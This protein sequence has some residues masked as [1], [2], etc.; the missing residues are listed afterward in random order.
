MQGSKFVEHIYDVDWRVG[1]FSNFFFRSSPS[2][3]GHFKIDDLKKPLKKGLNLPVSRGLTFYYSALYL[4][5]IIQTLIFVICQS[6]K[7]VKY[8]RF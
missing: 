5:D 2:V 3:S 7:T 8:K 1:S 6:L 4:K